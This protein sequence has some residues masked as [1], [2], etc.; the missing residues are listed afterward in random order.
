VN[1]PVH[2]DVQ[3]GTPVSRNAPRV[4]CVTAWG[5]R[6]EVA[7]FIGLKERGCEV[8]VCAMP[9]SPNLDTFERAGLPVLKLPLRHRV[10]LPTIRALRAE[11]LRGRYDV[12][13]MFHNR[14]ISNGLIASR[15]VRE[16]KIVVY[17]GIVGNTSYLDP[18]AW[19]RHLHPRVDRVVCV[20]EAV[21]ES[22]L[23]VGFLGLKLPPHKLVT[24]HKGHDLSWY[25]A[26]P[27]DLAQFGIPRDAFVIG[28]IANWRPRKG[29]EILLDAFAALPE[30]LPVFLLLA[31]R[32][33]SPGLIRAVERNPRRDRI[34]YLGF[35]NDAPSL[36]AACQVAV[37]PTTRREGLPKTVIE[38]MAYGVAPVVTDCGG[39]PELVVD[40]Q[41]GLVVPPGNASALSAAL[42]ELYCDTALRERLG[43][44]ARERIANEFNI[45]RTIDR[46][47]AL[48]RE[49]LDE[50]HQT[51]LRNRFPML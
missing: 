32:M 6:P 26:Q 38:A 39:S 22:L 15:G 44:A 35:R 2:P 23:D 36:I 34:R 1:E 9:S 16:L 10:D 24:I 33:E 7:T 13:H 11:L 30:R 50:R 3:A 5:D 18:T 19:L 8:R 45:T 37:L 41:C 25:S 47:L 27:V 51:A 28:C 43:R 49:L 31:G 48:Y 12:L 20:A 46:T 40:R 17:R 4:L 14:A 21:R 42:Y 29:L